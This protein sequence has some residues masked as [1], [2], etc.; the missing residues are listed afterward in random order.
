MKAGSCIKTKD[1]K[2]LFSFE[3]VSDRW[4][5]NVKDIYSDQDREEV[6]PTFN[7]LNGPS[8]LESEEEAA[9]KKPGIGKAQGIDDILTG[10]LI[11]WEIQD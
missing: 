4:Q 11:T 6:P 2:R 1:G 3:E 5:E 9:I 7:Y 10:V 8:I